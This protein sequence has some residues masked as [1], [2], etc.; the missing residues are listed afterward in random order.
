MS[1]LTDRLYASWLRANGHQG[2]RRS[3]GM[4]V[5]TPMVTNRPPTLSIPS[6]D[7][8]QRANDAASRHEKP[9]LELSINAES[10]LDR[11]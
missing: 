4:G 5:V 11:K 3:G 10:A 2:Q 9:V 6:R 1:A 7:G 8:L